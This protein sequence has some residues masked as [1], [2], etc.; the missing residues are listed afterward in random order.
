MNRITGL[1]LP[2]YLA[3][4]LQDEYVLYT[5]TRTAHW[6]IEGMDLKT[7]KIFKRLKTTQ[8]FVRGFTRGRSKS[9]EHFRFC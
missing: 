9:T 6:N 7:F 2:E 5:K 3:R 4:T 1:K 8:T